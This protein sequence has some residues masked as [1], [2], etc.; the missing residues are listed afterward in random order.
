M[1]ITVLIPALNPTESLLDVVRE[2]AGREQVKRIL[3]VNDGSKPE[4]EEV[5]TWAATTHAKVELLR[6]AVNMG[7]GAALRTGMN[8]FLCKHDADEVLVTAD[9]DGQHLP[10]DII[11]VGT[12]AIET[13]GEL[14]LGARE[15]SGE[16]PL[17]SRFGN[18]L[19]RMIFRLLI[20]RKVSD[21]QT[22]LRAIP[23]ALMQ[24]LM[25]LKATGYEF[26]LEMLIIAAREHITIS[27][28]TIQTVY[29]DGN[30]SSHF[31]PLL[32]SMRIYFV[33]ARFL[34]SSLLAAALDFFIF[35]VAMSMA[36]P[37]GWAMV[38]ARVA[39]GTLNHTMN[40]LYVF[41]SRRGWWDSLGMYAVSTALLGL[42]SF[43]SIEA[44][45]HHFDWSPIFA[46]L[47]MEALIFIC[48]FAVQRAFVFN[49]PWEAD[50]SED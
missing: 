5:F 11:K 26:E 12:Q 35:A 4:H 38:V 27:S 46:K 2:L 14:V 36:V 16:V 34:S 23:V 33:F 44:L 47:V 17:R 39:S 3:L 37:L 13:P 25:R 24:K 15:F 45:M 50:E 28:V 32:D 20:G 41:H 31:N 19:T 43:F 10:D 29:L 8:H 21:T 9:A 7:K 48:S 6:H 49:R 30:A 42:L 18:D 1:A 40:R 22:G